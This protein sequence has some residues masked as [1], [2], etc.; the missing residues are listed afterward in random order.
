MIDLRVLNNAYMRKIYAISVFL[1]CLFN[2]SYAQNC[3]IKFEYTTVKSG[4]T[5]NLSLKN[6]ELSS[7]Y[8]LKLYDLN[9]GKLLETKT[10]FF[11]QN[12]NKLVFKNLITGRYTVYIKA[13]GCDNSRT[14]GGIT[15][16]Y[17]TSER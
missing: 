14:I 13:A 4:D 3:D 7:Q 6:S 10:V 5:F 8:E 12:E 17:L 16:I 15:G 9:N 2:S 11:T 1:M